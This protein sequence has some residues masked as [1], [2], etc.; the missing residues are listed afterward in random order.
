[1]SK[2]RLKSTMSS[3]E[4][5]RG[6]KKECK[7]RERNVKGGGREGGRD[8]SSGNGQTWVCDDSDPSRLERKQRCCSENLCVPLERVSTDARMLIVPSAHQ[9][10]LYSH[11]GATICDHRCAQDE[12]VH[13]HSYLRLNR[14]LSSA[15]SAA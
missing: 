14:R 10:S 6:E 15:E 13:G 7:K 2:S 5:G 3:G 8:R 11:K 1:M 4:Q 9:H 12:N